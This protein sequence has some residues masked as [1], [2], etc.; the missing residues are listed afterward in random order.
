MLRV[1]ADSDVVNVTAFIAGNHY[2]LTQNSDGTWTLNYPI[3]GLADGFQT[4]LLT[5]TNGLGSQGTAYTGFTVDNTAPALKVEVLPF[6]VREGGKLFVRVYSDVDAVVVTAEILGKTYNLIKCSNSIWTLT[7]TVPGLKDG[8]YNVMLRGWDDLNNTNNTTV[9]FKVQNPVTPI[10]HGSLGGATGSS[11]STVHSAS[12]GY[13]N[14]V[15]SVQGGSSGSAVAV[16][17]VS[18]IAPVGGGLSAIS[19]SSSGLLD[20]F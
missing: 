14:G 17:V 8:N 20:G 16:K 9:T 12:Q 1:C 6:T 15:H 3:Q 10:N 18:P 7:C 5:A 19:S 13:S 4:V 11:T 2:N